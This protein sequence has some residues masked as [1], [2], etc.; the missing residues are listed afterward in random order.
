MSPTAFA[1]GVYE[2]VSRIPPGRV[3]TYALVA[4]AVGCG[5]PRAV[6]QAL[7]QNPYAPHVPCHRVV[8][9]DLRVGGFKGRGAGAAVAEK[10]A[11][12]RR[13]GVPFSGP[14]LVA[15]EAVVDP[16]ERSHRAHLL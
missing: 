4:R 11:L 1:A 9:S 10:I 2:V 6:G 7:R 12:L 8:R 14:E 16:A 15:P 3:T 13:E 5:S